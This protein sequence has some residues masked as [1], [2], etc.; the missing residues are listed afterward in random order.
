MATIK[1]QIE[2]EEQTLHAWK[3]KAKEQHALGADKQMLYHR[4]QQC[5]EMLKEVAHDHAG[6]AGRYNKILLDSIIDNDWLTVAYLGINTVF[7]AVAAQKSSIQA[8]V[9]KIG[10]RIEDNYK[11]TIFEQENKKTVA[12]LRDTLKKRRSKDADHA[13]RLLHHHMSA[14]EISWETWDLHT[15]SHIGSR[16][17]SA[18]VDVYDDIFEIEDYNTGIKSNKRIIMTGEFTAWKDK[19]VDFR[20]SWC[21]PPVPLKIPPMQWGDDFKS[22]F[23]T[24]RMK[25][26]KIK[27]YTKSH[28]ETFQ[29]C[30]EVDDALNKQGNTAWIIDVSML[31]RV[32]YVLQTGVY[33][34]IKKLAPAK[35]TALAEHLCTE[36]LSDEQK[37][38]KREWRWEE[39]DAHTA[40]IS[41]NARML[42]LSRSI[43][44]AAELA[45]WKQFY[46]VYTVDLTGRMYCNSSTI[47][48][49]GGDFDKSLLSFSKQYKISKRG[50]EWL[51]IT[52][53]KYYGKKGSQEDLYAWY[54]KN[55]ENIQEVANNADSIWWTTAKSPWC[56]LRT[57]LEIHKEYSGFPVPLDGVCNG[58]QHYATLTRN[59]QAAQRLGMIT[60]APQDLYSYIVAVIE[61]V[62]GKYDWLTRDFLK[63]P[64]MLTCYGVTISNIA[65]RIG[66]DLIDNLPNE[67]IKEVTALIK[68]VLVQ[69]LEFALQGMKLIQQSYNGGYHT[70]TSPTGFICYQSYEMQDTITIKVNLSSTVRINLKKNTGKPNKRKQ[71]SALPANYIHSLDAAHAT[72]VANAVP[73]DIRLTHD[74]FAVPCNKVDDLQQI[75]TR[76]FVDMYKDLRLQDGDLDINEILNKKYFFC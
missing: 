9:L 65:Y 32:Q 20:S 54:C 37:T 68:Q 43:K 16:V 2:F 56:F 1:D 62:L 24:E 57:C 40:N 46:F 51:C 21:T 44:S 47:N 27:C 55:I 59:K 15:K 67:K 13:R 34:R 74:E 3:E 58:L 12:Y 29:P 70:W 6:T 14:K 72:F 52:A 5:A 42:R 11:Y 33:Q 25:L 35:H 8:I 61:A 36:E 38:L 28:R 53:A 73:Y 71:R 26:D 64:V 41:V 31:N 48:T 60:N 18:I 4:L 63:K 7:D 30:K 39:R 49:Q 19:Y 23:Y 69:E 22:G 10:T 17:L 50:R 76:T 45:L 75:I 66:R